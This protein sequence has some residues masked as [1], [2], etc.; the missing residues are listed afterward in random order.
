[1]SHRSQTSKRSPGRGA[2]AETQRQAE[3]RSRGR[4][5]EKHKDRGKHSRIQSPEPR[6]QSPAEKLTGAWGYPPLTLPPPFSPL[7][8]TCDYR[9]RPTPIPPLPAPLQPITNQGQSPRQ[10]L[11]LPLPTPTLTPDNTHTGTHI[12][13]HG[14]T[15]RLTEP[16]VNTG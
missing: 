15:H 11:H 4:Q 2:R 3:D 14:Q 5:G 6:A 12:D 16:T 8:K 13:T 9:P 7:G 1:M 10:V